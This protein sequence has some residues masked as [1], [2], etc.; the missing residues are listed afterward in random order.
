MPA[1]AWLTRASR[2]RPRAPRTSS[3]AASGSAVPRPARASGASR[4]RTGSRSTSGGTGRDKRRRLTA[5]GATLDSVTHTPRRA[6]GHYGDR[7]WAS[8]TGSGKN[9]ARRAVV[10]VCRHRHAAG[11]RVG[12]AAARPETAAE[13]IFSAPAPQNT[14]PNK[15]A[16]SAW[17]YFCTVV[18][19][20]GSVECRTAAPSPC[21]CPAPRE[22]AAPTPRAARSGARSASALDQ[23]ALRSVGHAHPQRHRAR[24]APAPG[25]GQRELQQPG[26]QGRLHAPQCKRP[27]G[28]LAR[29]SS[30]AASGSDGPRPAGARPPIAAAPSPCPSA[31]RR[32]SV[33][34]T[35]RRER[36]PRSSSRA[37]RKGTGSG[38]VFSPRKRG[39]RRSPCP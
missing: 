36:A 6:G 29:T 1:A 20:S 28:S 21:P 13:S 2:R 8:R 30:R 3:R 19:P 35:S 27:S 39:V 37:S 34:R 11:P 32:E 14:P 7:A 17:A 10:F 16:P 26:L 15:G 18:P 31:S 25:R 4:T 33:A 23:N 38:A 22:S 12:R 9:C 24:R 5:P